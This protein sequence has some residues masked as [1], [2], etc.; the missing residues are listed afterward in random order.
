[1]SIDQVENNTENNT[2]SKEEVSRRL[3]ILLA[4]KP[5]SGTI[6]TTKDGLPVEVRFEEKDGEDVYVNCSVDDDATG[7]F[8]SGLS[9]G[10]RC[11]IMNKS[12]VQ[13]IARNKGSW[14]GLKVSKLL[15]VRRSDSGRSL[16]CE[17]V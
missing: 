8:I 5:L 17:L 9:R 2:D 7:W 14:N 4:N 11:I 13:L 6:L 1:M 10:L 16:I 3:K 12:K 15:V